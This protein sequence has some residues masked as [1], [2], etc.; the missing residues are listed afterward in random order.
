MIDIARNIAL[1]VLYKMDESGAYSNIALDDMLKNNRKALSDRDV[2]LISQIVYGVTTW[3]LT[4]DEIIKKYSSIKLKK[5]SIWII[6]ILRMG[7]YQIIF[8]DK[9]PKSA[10]VNECVNLAKRYGHKA[11]S[12]FVNAILRKVSPDDYLQLFDVKLPKAEMISKTQSMPLWIIEELLENNTIEEV[13]EICKNLNLTPCV[14]IRVNNVKTT[15]KELEE[16]FNK[17]SIQYEEGELDDFLI[18]N[19]AKNIENIE[20]FKE[21]LFTVQDESAGLTCLVLNPK[22]GQM[23]LDACSAPGGK[24]TYIAEIMKNTGNIIAWD[25]YEHRI[26]L[27]N[28]NANRLGLKNINTSINDAS[29]YNENYKEKFDKI[30]LDVPCLGIGVIRRKPDIKWQRK[31]EDVYEISKLQ[32]KILETCSKYLKPGG[33]LVYSTCSI[34]KKENEGVILKFLENNKD[35]EIKK[36]DSNKWNEYIK[37]EKYFSIK[38]DKK[39]DGFFICKLH[40]NNI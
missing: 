11:S 7:I 24:T 34:L 36:L 15:K 22:E 23:V 19:K 3:K 14:S 33:E 25:V 18:L 6:N 13:E 32:Y 27:I 29:I 9:I 38:P 17:N 28:E 12:G 39:H 16:I 30:L 10:A 21:G 5:I 26:N 4:L 40:K 1:E 35:F 31:Q 20:G 2:S 37:E 8:L